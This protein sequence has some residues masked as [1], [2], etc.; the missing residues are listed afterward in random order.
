MARGKYAARATLR[1]ED[2]G[3]RSELDGR[4]HAID[5]LTAEN[6]QLRKKLARQNQAMRA[7]IRRLEKAVES[8]TTP[9]VDDL[10]EELHHQREV[11]REA[12]AE[13]ASL[14][15]RLVETTRLAE[16]ATGYTMVTVDAQAEEGHVCP[17]M[18]VP[19]FGVAP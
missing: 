19:D 9:R 3:V 2:A 15:R 12:V 16:D 6:A 17:H 11:A 14:R 13:A 1:R 4:Q 18:L 8:G 7:E 5:R 10:L